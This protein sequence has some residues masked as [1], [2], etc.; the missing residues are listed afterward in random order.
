MVKL[1]RDLKKPHHSYMKPSL[2]FS[3]KNAYEMSFWLIE[4]SNEVFSKPR[5]KVRQNGL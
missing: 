3:T 4:T 1:M 5:I 2:A